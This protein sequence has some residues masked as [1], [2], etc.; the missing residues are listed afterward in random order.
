MFPRCKASTIKAHGFTFQKHPH[1]TN[2]HC[3]WIMG[4]WIM[5]SDPICYTGK[6]RFPLW[7]DDGQRRPGTCQGHHGLG[8][9][10]SQ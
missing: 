2:T 1:Q 10:R 8:G 6:D 4:A 9:S 7:T 5:G 3:M